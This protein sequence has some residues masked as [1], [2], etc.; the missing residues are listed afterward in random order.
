VT[1]LPGRY[2]SRT[3]NG[4]NPGEKRIRM[5][6]VA[7]LEECIEGAKRIKALLDTL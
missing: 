5:A 3:V 4:K 7:P 1:V 6:L 2:L